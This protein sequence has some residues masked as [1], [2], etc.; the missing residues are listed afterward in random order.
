MAG[1]CASIRGGS[2]A[3]RAASAALLRRCPLSTA[4]TAP[5][6]AVAPAATGAAAPPSSRAAAAAATP[7]PAAPSASP[8]QDAPRRPQQLPPPP[9]V[10]FADPREAFRSKTSGELARGLLVLALCS[11]DPLVERAPQVSRANDRRVRARLCLPAGNPAR[12]RL[13]VGP[14]Q[15]GW[16]ILALPPP[17][18]RARGNQGAPAFVCLPA[19]QSFR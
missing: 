10:D 13:A 15:P 9:V 11:L 8:A 2:R 17:P 4:A 12:R 1:S 5:D 16:R 19:A 6:P 7:A 18:A 3:L 14:A